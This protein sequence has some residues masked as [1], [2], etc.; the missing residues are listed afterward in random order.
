MSLD[1]FCKNKQS[2]T[3]KRIVMPSQ[4]F[5]SREFTTFDVPRTK[6]VRFTNCRFYSE[7]GE[8]VS[9]SLSVLLRLR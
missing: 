5:I 1:T 7:Y 2:K 4:A 9:V 8:S 3:L 6:G